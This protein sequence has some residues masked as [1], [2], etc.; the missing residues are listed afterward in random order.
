[1]EALSV[2]VD[3]P[4]PVPK[5]VEAPVVKNTTTLA[6]PAAKNSTAQIHKEKVVAKK[7]EPAKNTTAKAVIP[8]KL[9]SS[10]VKKVEPA[11]NK[12]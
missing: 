11:K 6:T 3:N 10:A 12:T 1:M 7:S 5:A 4:T 2:K 8:Q 9:A